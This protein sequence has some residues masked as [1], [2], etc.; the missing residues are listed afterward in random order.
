MIY[1]LLF[2][3]AIAS[4]SAFY[5]C[6][7]EG[8]HYHTEQYMSEPIWHKINH[9]PCVKTYEVLCEES[10]IHA[11]LIA[12]SYISKYHTRYGYYKA[13][14]S[15]PIVHS[16]ESCKVHPLYEIFDLI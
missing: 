14:S 5:V 12:K 3:T 6:S 11:G 15:E 1:F 4:V 10:P 13:F 2:Y 8:I 9:N 16:Y 7:Y